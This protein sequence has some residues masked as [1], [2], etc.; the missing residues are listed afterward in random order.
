LGNFSIADAK[1]VLQTLTK[2]S[3][4]DLS[5]DLV[6]ALIE[7][8]AGEVREV[9]PIELQIV[10]T[11]LEKR[12]ITQLGKYQQL[13]T[14]AKLKL[15]EEFLDE[16]IADCGKE[17][18]KIAKVVLYLLTDEN[19]T[20]PQKNFAELA[21]NLRID[22]V[23]E[24]ELALEMIVKSGLVLEVPGTPKRYQLVHDY[25]VPFVRHW[26]NTKLLE[27]NERIKKIEASTQTAEELLKEI[28]KTNDQM[29]EESKEW[30]AIL[31]R[32]IKIVAIFIIINII[33][34]SIRA[35]D[36]IIRGVA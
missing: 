11:Q 28:L 26:D 21:A 27:I 15:V 29:Q 22:L 35:V 23:E 16:V 24:L 7:D 4:L 34:F 12:Q 25:L 17:N 9:R 31:K 14:Q 6:N 2:R 10:G 13:G 33:M 8:L 30:L 19:N 32:D 1:I 20:R 5:E 3:Q 36:I 18:K